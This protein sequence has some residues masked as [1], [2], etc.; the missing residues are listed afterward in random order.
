MGNYGIAFK[1]FFQGLGHEVILPPAITRETIEAGVRASP[2]SMCF[3]FKINVGNC[4]AAVKQGA[5]TIGMFDTRGQCR[6]RYYNILLRKTLAELGIELPFIIFTPWDGI[7]MFWRTGRLPVI[8]MIRVCR[9]TWRKVVLIESIEEYASR[10]RPREKNKGETDTVTRRCLALL[11]HAR[12]RHQLRDVAR[13]I[14]SLFA[15]VTV[16]RDRHPLSIGLVGEI[17]AVTEPALNQG[18]EQILGQLGAQ[19]TRGIKITSYVSHWRPRVRRRFRA[20]ARPYLGSS[21]GG[22]GLY[23]VAETIQFAQKGFD[24]IVHVAP[25]GCMPETT[26][27][28][29]LARISEEYDTPLLSLTFDEHSSVERV[30]TRLEAFVDVAR[31][32]KDSHAGL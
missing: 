3:P 2:E 30:R 12:T 1:S 5:D 31:A 4:I 23:T 8:D 18:L 17:Y 24:G 29:I 27:R 25:F 10:L 22:H 13:A 14:Q 26:V 6:F 16:A 28:P 11:D 15:S 19:V 9:I 21:V 20:I 32:R 7:R